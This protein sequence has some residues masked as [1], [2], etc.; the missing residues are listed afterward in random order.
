MSEFYVN[1]EFHADNPGSGSGICCASVLCED[2]TEKRREYIR[3]AAYY[4]HLACPQWSAEQC[5]L[6]GEIDIDNRYAFDS[7]LAWRS[8]KYVNYLH[9]HYWLG[10]L[11]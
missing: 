3:M 7:S 9:D 1:N 5:W 6:R 4:V 11:Q 8:M 2:P 10:S